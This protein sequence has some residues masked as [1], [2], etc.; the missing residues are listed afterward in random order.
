MKKITLLFL[1]VFILFGCQSK[2][3]KAQELIKEN[4]FKVLYD[5]SSYE[6][7]ELKVDSSFT[8]IYRDSSILS[9][10]YIIKTCYERIDKCL[11]E[12]KDAQNTME[13]WSSGYSDTSRRKRKE[14][15]EKYNENL[16]NARFSLELV[17]SSQA[18]IA[19]SIIDFKPV[20]DGWK[21]THKFR[22]KTKGG[23]Y[24]IG[25]Y[26]YY[27]DVKMKEILDYDDI[28]SDNHKTIINIINEVSEDPANFISKPDESDKEI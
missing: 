7:I 15:T 10:A 28:D 9:E 20:F 12:I 22:C 26:V 13:I 18:N 3:E 6:P 2:E 8:S 23:N 16:D 17:N 25:N 21:A 14:A 24:D 4:M 19:K 27:F 11:E 5:Y 1:S